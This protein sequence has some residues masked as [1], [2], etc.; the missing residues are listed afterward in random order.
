MRHWGAWALIRRYEPVLTNALGERLVP[1]RWGC[2]MTRVMMWAP[3]VPPGPH[4]LVDMDSSFTFGPMWVKFLA[5]GNNN[6]KVTWV[7]IKPAYLLISRPM[8]WP[9]CYTA[10]HTHTHTHT[11]THIYSHMHAHRTHTHTC[12]YERAYT[13]TC[14]HSYVRTHMYTHTHMYA[15]MC[16]HFY[17]F[18]NHMLNLSHSFFMALLIR[19]Y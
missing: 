18:I 17:Q 6:T 15:C 8:P 7:E 9:L 19:L 2:S 12:A 3:K 10:S 16:A 4:P 5:Q 11:H 14:K 1:C 13:C